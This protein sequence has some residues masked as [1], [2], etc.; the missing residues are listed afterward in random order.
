MAYTLVVDFVETVSSAMMNSIHTCE[1]DMK[2]VLFVNGTGLEINSKLSTYLLYTGL[3]A[4]DATYY[5]FFVFVIAL[6]ITKVWY[7]NFHFHTSPWSFF[8]FITYFFFF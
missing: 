5:Y 4:D 2:N 6:R 3:L 8:S 7:V 1:K